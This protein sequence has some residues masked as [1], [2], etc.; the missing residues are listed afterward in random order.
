LQASV[1]GLIAVAQQVGMTTLARVGRD[2]LE[3]SQ[4]YDAAAFG[5]T[6]ARLGRIGE[7]SLMA[8]WDLQDLSV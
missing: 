3:L 6:V 2:V 8:V 5:A 7:S 4:S 1:R